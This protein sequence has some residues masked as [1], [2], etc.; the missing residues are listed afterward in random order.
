MR[1]RGKR[2]RPPEPAPG[3]VENMPEPTKS[4]LQSLR[5]RLDAEVGKPLSPE[6]HQRLQG[7]I[8]W[9]AWRLDRAVLTWEQISYQRWSVVCRLILKY[10][11]EHGTERGSRKRV[12]QDA[13]ELL[14]GSPYEGSWTTIKEDFLFQERV[15]TSD[16]PRSVRYREALERRA[17]EA[18]KNQARRR[19]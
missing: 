10:V 17:R 18:D 4:D 15:S 3:V 11:A 12:Y 2:S 7:L 5:D 14:A 6:L 8:S 13:A 9:A 1:T 19:R 16:D